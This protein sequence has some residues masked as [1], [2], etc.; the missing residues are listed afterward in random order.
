MKSANMQNKA[1]QTNPNR[2]LT[3]CYLENGRWVNMETSD[4]T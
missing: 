1:Y 4:K 3:G 2:L